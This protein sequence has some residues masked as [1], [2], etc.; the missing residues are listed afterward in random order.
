MNELKKSPVNFTSNW[1][2]WSHEKLGGVDDK[3][4]LAGGGGFG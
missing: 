2:Y 3:F 4:L 1:L